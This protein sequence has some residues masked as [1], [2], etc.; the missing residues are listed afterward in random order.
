MALSPSPERAMAPIVS[1]CDRT[2]WPIVGCLVCG[3]VLRLIWPADMEWKAD[4]IWMW[5]HTQQIL[6]GAIP[7]PSVGMRTSLEVPN[8]VV[9]T[10]IFLALAKLSPTPVR[11]VQWIQ[12]LNVLTLWGFLGFILSQVRS[13]ARPIW[14]WG[15]AI[16]SV[17]PA[18]M[19]LARKL[20]LPDLIAP[21]CLLIL[22][23]HWFRTRFWGSLLWG[24]A[25]MLCGQIHM[26][27]F[28]VAF[29]LGVWTVWQDWGKRN[30]RTHWLGYGIGTLLGALPL[31]PWA[32]TVIPNLDVYREFMD[33]HESLNLFPRFYLQW[34]TAA[35]GVNLS[36]AL[37][38]K[39]WTEFL[40]EP[41][42]W[43]VPTYLMVPAH[44]FLTG[45]G[46]YP[47]YR[48]WRNRRRRSLQFISQ[49]TIPVP[50]I[51]FYCGALAWGA[52]G[53]FSLLR[54]NVHS[55]YLAVIFPFHYLWLAQLYRHRIWLLGAIALSQLLIS[56]TFLVFIHRTGGYPFGET[57][58]GITYWMQQLQQE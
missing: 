28:F 40:A 14:L 24:A 7:L 12:W 56:A 16:A 15:L 32:L 4:E 46:L 27:G 2:L 35:L 55:H 43:G 29:G 45:I 22:I 11:L 23:G 58:F 51:N 25:V 38:S 34:L 20:W 9:G 21:F 47:V 10:W 53:L 1:G 30:G 17:N 37:W 54:V 39:F 44:G 50:K 33:E 52:G 13:S 26:G 6:T 5:E 36:N 18:A 42:V 48:W 19:L 31:I 49:S 41:R 8:S 3:T 57:E